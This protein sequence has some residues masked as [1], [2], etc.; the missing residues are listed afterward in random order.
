MSS[1]S[2]EKNII[3]LTNTAAGT[4]SIYLLVLGFAN[5]FLWIPCYLSSRNS[6]LH[7]LLSLRTELGGNSYTWY[8][9]TGSLCMRSLLCNALSFFLVFELFHSAHVTPALTVLDSAPVSGCLTSPALFPVSFQ[10]ISLWLSCNVMLTTEHTVCCWWLKCVFTVLM[11]ICLVCLF[12]DVFVFIFLK[13]VYAFVS[14][15]HSSV[16][17]SVCALLLEN[18]VTFWFSEWS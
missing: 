17:S 6:L 13:P 1:P 9:F 3:K 5:L 10:Q 2:L 7:T 16:L 18:C 4:S 8:H 15:Y 14:P 12:V 11:L